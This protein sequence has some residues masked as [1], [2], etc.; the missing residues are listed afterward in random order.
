MSYELYQ[1]S[2]EY[3][4]SGDYATGFHLFEHRW[5]P[6]TQDNFPPEN[7]FTKLVPQP[8]WRGENLYGRSI[9][10]QMEMGYGDCIQFARFLP[11]LKTIGAKKIV[12]LQTKSLHNL[13]SQFYCLDSISNN[14]QIG[15]SVETDYWIGSMSLPYFIL[16]SRPEFRYLFPITPKYVVG[17]TGYFSA[18]PAELEGQIR[19]GVNWEPSQTWGYN[20]RR[21]DEDYIGQLN[22]VFP[23]VTFYSLN[24]KSAGPFR[25]LPDN[26]WR[27]DWSLTASYIAAM[28]AVITIDTSTVHMAGALGVP[29]FMLQPE[30]KYIC[31]RWSFSNW[32]QSVTTFKQ[33]ALE[34][35]ISYLKETDHGKHIL[36]EN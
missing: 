26:G 3:L 21:L 25:E 18:Q 36:M 31:W 8:V 28:N 30:D 22:Q 12:L 9:T 20:I 34:K 32:Y 16:H 1:Q 5:H 6:E 33:P 23:Q 4:R 15:D 27:E 17:S 2:Y 14:N 35:I 7:K 11:Y 10:V 13:M 19:I 29:T 24:P